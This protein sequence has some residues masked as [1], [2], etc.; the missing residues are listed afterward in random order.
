MLSSPLGQVARS[1]P[2]IARDRI[3]KNF[4]R[5]LLSAAATSSRTGSARREPDLQSDLH[6]EQVTMKTLISLGLS[7]STLLGICGYRYGAEW[8]YPELPT[9][10]QAAE[11]LCEKDPDAFFGRVKSEGTGDLAAMNAARNGIR[12][13]L[14]ELETAAEEQQAKL[15]YARNAAEK[16]RSAWQAGVF[17][18]EVEGRAYTRNDLEAQV[19]SLL[20]QIDGYEQAVN[21]ISRA[22]EEA[23]AQIEELTVQ[24]VR[25]E[26]D[27]SLLDIRRE[28]FRAT[29][30]DGSVAE[31]MATVDSLFRRNA[32]VISTSPIRSVDELMRDAST[33]DST[34][35]IS[36]ARAVD[37][38]N[39][40]VVAN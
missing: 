39:Q 23:G 25:T 24:I 1:Q 30:A 28:V 3:A 36:R 8:L 26:T 12:G 5:N 33:G 34:R 20:A 40:S 15:S 11:E 14:S 29:R 7:L 4:S 19:S 37:F 6:E 21:K 9:D 17:P 13:R 35:P 2:K 22:R 38:L 31:L 32:E 27:L 18:V 10:R 16:F